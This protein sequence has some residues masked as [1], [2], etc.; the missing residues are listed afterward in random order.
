VF[1]AANEPKALYL[2]EGA[3]HN[4]VDLVGG[5]VYFTRVLEFVRRVTPD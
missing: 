2:V 5:E 3:D 1:E 4:D